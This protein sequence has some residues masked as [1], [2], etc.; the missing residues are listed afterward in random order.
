MAGTHQELKNGIVTDGNG[1]VVLDIFGSPHLA[2]A[3]KTRADAIFVAVF[4]CQ[5]KISRLFFQKLPRR[6]WAG[7]RVITYQGAIRNYF[8][9]VLEVT[10]G[11]LLSMKGL[12]ERLD[13]QYV[14]IKILL[15]DKMT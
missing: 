1:S 2:L 14:P 7:I 12:R 6:Q 10:N 5:A 3:L 11:M 4:H 9:N 13:A 15:L 8:G